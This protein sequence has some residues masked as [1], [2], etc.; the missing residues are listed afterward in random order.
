MKKVQPWGDDQG[1]F[2]MIDDDQFDPDFH[3]EIVDPA[4]AKPPKGKSKSDA[5]ASAQ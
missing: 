4:P 1:D 5:G 2:V 3:V